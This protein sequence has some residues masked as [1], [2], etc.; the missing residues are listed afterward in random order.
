MKKVKNP[1]LIILMGLPATGKSFLANLLEEKFNFV[2]VSGENITYQLFKK[3]ACTVKQYE[4]VYKIARLLTAKFLK[5]GYN[6]VF[7]GTNLKKKYRKQIYEVTNNIQ[8]RRF[9]LWVKARPK[10]I[11]ERIKKMNI[12]YKNQNNIRSRITVKKFDAFKK[13]LEPPTRREIK[14]YIINNNGNSDICKQLKKILK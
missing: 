3:T 10:I 1:T 12:N 2:K 13:Q 6:V 14:T 8:V 11:F 7:D 4:R 5:N 9:L